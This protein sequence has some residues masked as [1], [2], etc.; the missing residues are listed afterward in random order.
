LGAVSFR[1]AIVGLKIQSTQCHKRALISRLISKRALLGAVSFRMAIVVG[2]TGRHLD[3]TIR[4]GGHEGEKGEITRFIDVN[5]NPEMRLEGG[6]SACQMH[7]TRTC[8]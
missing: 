1:M 2:L 8:R 5:N 6:Q 3:V 7:T 4:L